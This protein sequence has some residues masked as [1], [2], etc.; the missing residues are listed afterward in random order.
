MRRFAAILAVLSASAAFGQYTPPGNRVAPA[1]SPPTPTATGTP[2]VSPSGA[3]PTSSASNGMTGNA[4]PGNTTAYPGANPVGP[5]YGG[6]T[7]GGPADAGGDSST[8]SGAGSTVST[9]PQVGDGSTI[10]AGP[11]VGPPDISEPADAGV[12]Y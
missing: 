3:Q 2:T 11:Q 12:R 7:T 1:P 4:A 8:F 9:G 10:G 5:G 6:A